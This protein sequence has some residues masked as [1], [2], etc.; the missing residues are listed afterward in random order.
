MTYFSDTELELMRTYETPDKRRDE[1][2]LFLSDLEREREHVSLRRRL[3]GFFVGLGL[4]L[5]P[6][7]ALSDGR[8][9]AAGAAHD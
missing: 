2:I 4:R 8:F 3:A 9:A 1:R 5:D 6:Q 7:A